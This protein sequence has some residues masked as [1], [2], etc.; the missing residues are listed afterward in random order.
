MLS[1]AV[2]WLSQH[3]RQNDRWL[4]CSVLWLTWCTATLTPVYCQ[5]LSALFT[6][7]SNHPISLSFASRRTVPCSNFQCHFHWFW[8]L[9]QFS[10]FDTFHK[11]SLKLSELLIKNNMEVLTYSAHC[12]NTLC[13]CI[14]E[15]LLCYY[16]SIFSSR[17]H[18]LDSVA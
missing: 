2:I 3:T 17:I 13:F 4:K 18:K 10:G 5:R 15:H 8:Y 6:L 1:L 16:L 9:I 7:K 14:V 12:Q 11:H